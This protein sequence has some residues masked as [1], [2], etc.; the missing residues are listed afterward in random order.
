[1]S[2]F[3]RNESRAQRSDRSRGRRGPGR[4]RGTRAAVVSLLLAVA[5]SA[6]VLFVPS[7][8]GSEVV[9]RGDEQIETTREVTSTSLLEDQPAPALRAVAIALILAG[10]PIAVNRSRFR[11]AARTGSAVLL[12]VGSI[13]AGFSIGLFYMPSAAA[14]TFAAVRSG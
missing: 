6:F 8:S 9:T 14:M 3:G 5:A 1:M 4:P 13:V 12:W 7:Q 10:A 11:P 2:A